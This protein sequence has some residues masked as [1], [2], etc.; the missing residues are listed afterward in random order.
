MPVDG[1]AAD[2][3]AFGPDPQPKAFLHR[4]EDLDGLPHHLR[5]DAVAS[6]YSDFFHPASP[7]AFQNLKAAGNYSGLRVQ[8]FR[9]QEI[10]LSHPNPES[11][12]LEQ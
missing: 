6:Q 9:V 8:E 10:Q 4:I 2:V 11:S 5:P 7:C 3:R 12:L 1:A